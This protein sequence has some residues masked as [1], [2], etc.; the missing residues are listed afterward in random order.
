M[1]DK[2]RIDLYLQYLD[3][4]T[5]FQMETPE[6]SASISMCITKLNEIFSRL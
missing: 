1:T 4:L 6:V 3:R 5:K 2:D